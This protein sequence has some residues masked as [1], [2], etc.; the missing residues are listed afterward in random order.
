MKIQ[1][2]ILIKTKKT[3]LLQEFFELMLNSKAVDLFFA[4][5]HIFT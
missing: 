1:K 3:N 2:I 4:G 5:Y